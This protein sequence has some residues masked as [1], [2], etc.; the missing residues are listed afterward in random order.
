M[1]TGSQPLLPPI[2]GLNLPGAFA[3][4]TR[5]DVR[6]ILEA[7][8]S[9]RRVAVV[10]GGLL[11]LEAARGLA[12]RGLQVTVIHLVDRIMERQLDATGARMLER[13]MNRLGIDVMLGPR[14]DGGAR[15]RSRRGRSLRLG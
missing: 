14:D 12:E 2:D 13:A 8:Q 5:E 1:A 7:G 15:R 3:F 11:G 10:G 4:R 9:A 6:R